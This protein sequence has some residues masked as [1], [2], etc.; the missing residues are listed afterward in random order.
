MD[1]L[2]ANAAC[3]VRSWIHSNESEDKETML[4][5]KL[6]L[7]PGHTSERSWMEPSTLKKLFWNVTYACNYQCPIC[8][9]DAGEPLA[10]EL[11]EAEALQTVQKIHEAGIRDVIISGG[12]P[13]MRRDMVQI[14]EKM[15]EF[16]ISTRIASNGSLLT[17]DILKELKDKTL[18]QSFQI[19]L[20]TVNPELYEKFHGSS[21]GSFDQTLSI[22][23]RIQAYD[24]HTTISV[25]L[26]PD[27]ISG[28]PRLLDLAHSEGWATVT[29][30][31]PL[32]TRRISNAYPQDADF[33]T[34]LTPAFESF[35]TLPEQWLIEIYIPWAEYHPSVKA[36]SKRIR[37]V[38]RG[39]RAG[40]DRLTINPTGM[41]SPCV[42][43]DVS[44]AYLG[45]VREDT[46][47]DVFEHSALCRMMKSPLEMGICEDC[48]NVEK[49]GGGC[50]AAAFAMS[51]K[52]D[53]LD[54]SCPVRKQMDN[55]RKA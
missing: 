54:R 21:P 19:S 49:C 36:L 43:L 29:V 42:C 47:L 4:D 31:I 11:N 34:L 44:E 12:E 10:E 25:R 24:F 18:T 46:L 6:K 17:D 3:P 27:T 37:V 45:N 8:F 5:I 30:H 50:R 22:L 52:I 14:L 38:N 41:I 53:A 55:K 13:F 20:D 28:I 32:H 7:K 48:A 23:R 2:F 16:G 26:T 39:C 1:V 35:L 51:G 40:R 9:T 15:A 33:F